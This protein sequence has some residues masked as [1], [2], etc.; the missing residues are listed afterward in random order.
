MAGIKPLTGAQTHIKNRAVAFEIDFSHFT[1]NCWA[2]GKTFDKKPVTNYLFNGSTIAS[3]RL[4]LSLIREGLKK[5]ICESCG[6][7][8]WMENEL[9]L[10]L[11]HKNGIHNDNRLENLQILCPNCHAIKTRIDRRSNKVHDNE[12]I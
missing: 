6:V 3:H 4:K 9:P 5:A 10:E 8:K 2:K 1:G 11:D 7:S 12:S